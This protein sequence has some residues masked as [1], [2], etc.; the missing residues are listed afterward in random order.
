VCNHPSLLENHDEL[1]GVCA[2]DALLLESRFE[3]LDSNLPSLYF[4]EQAHIEKAPVLRID[5]EL[6]YFLVRMRAYESETG[7]ELPEIGISE[8]EG[9]AIDLGQAV[10]DIVE[11]IQRGKYGEEFIIIA[12]CGE[13]SLERFGP[14]VALARQ[15]IQ[16]F[17]IDAQ[18]TPLEQTGG[19]PKDVSKRNRIKD[20]LGLVSAVKR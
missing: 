13:D 15:K 20:I 7:Q 6:P 17:R 18:N 9:G 19:S 3:I 10:D 14:H 4:R 1:L 16:E 11:E 8:S 5:D 2:G 12:E